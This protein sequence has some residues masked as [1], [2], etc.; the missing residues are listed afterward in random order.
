MHLDDLRLGKQRV[1]GR[2]IQKTIQQVREH[3]ACWSEMTSDDFHR[4]VEQLDLSRRDAG[5]RPIGW[6]RHPATIMWINSLEALMLYTDCMIREW[7]RRGKENT[8]PLMIT[9]GHNEVTT[10]M[11]EIA[12]PWWLGREDLHEAHRS[13]LLQKDPDHYAG[14]KENTREG[15]EMV[16]PEPTKN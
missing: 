5:L 4:S 2:T 16:W 3:A 7:V 12:M 13:V 9:A 1:E 11:S 15:L 6:S 14:F 10:A 8:M